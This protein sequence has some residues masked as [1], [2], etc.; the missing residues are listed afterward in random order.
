MKIC[1][2]L[3]ELAFTKYEEKTNKLL[4]LF[5]LLLIYISVSLIFLFS[6][7]SIFHYKDTLENDFTD[8]CVLIFLTK[9]ASFQFLTYTPEDFPEIDCCAVEDL[10]G[11]TVDWV[12]KQ[13]RGEKNEEKMLVNV[14]K[15][16]RIL[17]LKLREKSNENVLNAVKQLET[18]DDI[19]SVEPNYIMTMY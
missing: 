10:T 12:E 5:V 3:K 15:F 17:C 1:Y 19:F 16:R 18:R 14:A 13:V 9:T 2:K 11:Y 7:Y 4:K 6:M 8:D